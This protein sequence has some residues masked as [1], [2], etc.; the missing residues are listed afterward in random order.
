MSQLD[1]SNYYRGLLVLTGK[2][3]IV[4]LRERELMLR[5]GQLLDFD[6]RFCIAAID[7]LL[8]NKHITDEPVTFS[9][10]EIA[11]CFVRDGIRLICVDRE[12]HSKEMN[13]LKEVAKANGLTE[14]WL[15]AEVRRYRDLEGTVD[16]PVTLAVQQY[17][18]RTAP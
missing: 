6:L 12:I 4:D 9:N 14:E 15:D 18:S 1:R 3:R 17:L 7:D 5:F 8:E 13:W 11:Q 16:L 2:D 10:R